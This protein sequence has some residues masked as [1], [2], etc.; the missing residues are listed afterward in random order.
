MY[1]HCIFA[2]A[3]FMFIVDSYVIILT[4]FKNIFTM[5]LVQTVLH[6]ML[7]MLPFLPCLSTIHIHTISTWFNTTNFFTWY[8][9]WNCPY[10]LCEG[11]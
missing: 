7:Q 1:L 4:I 2:V 11:T 5:T 8:E 9:R 6:N 10:T 3:C